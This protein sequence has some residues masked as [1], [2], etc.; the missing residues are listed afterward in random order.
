MLALV[1]P[2]IKTNSFV[3]DGKRTN[4]IFVRSN[5]VHTD[6]VL[7]VKSKFICWSNFLLYSD[8]KEANEK[9]DYISIG[10]GDKGFFIAT[11]TWNDLKLSTAFNAAFGLSSTAM[12]V[13]YRQ[14]APQINQDCK[15]LLITDL[16]Y[17]ILVDYIISSFK[18][19][20]SG[21]ILIDHPGYT[22]N[23]RFYEANGVY[24][25]FKTCNVW[26]SMGLQVIGE[27]TGVWSPLANG[28]LQNID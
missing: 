8:F 10:W 4:T 3:I 24:S 2:F 9:Y 15:R 17:K 1:L 5:G 25:L 14:N 26:T 19:N 20:N 23:D 22:K 13:T 28:I 27:K 7:P 12:H 16:Q 11:P 18:K 21:F 6:F